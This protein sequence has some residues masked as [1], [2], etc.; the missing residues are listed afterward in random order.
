[1]KAA[2]IP[3]LLG[4]ALLG[5][6]GGAATVL[7]LAPRPPATRTVALAPDTAVAPPARDLGARLAELAAENRDLRER[8]AALELRPAVVP[9][10]PIEAFVP[11]ET[12]TAFEAEVRAALARRDVLPEAAPELKERVADV[13]IDLRRQEAQEKVRRY[14]EARAARLDQ[15]LEKLA[16]WLELNAHQA[17]EM[18]AVLER[19][20]TREDEV[21]RLWEEGVEDEVL[22]ERKRAD[23]ELFWAEAAEVLT[24][25]QLATFREGIGADGKD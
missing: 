21:R 8:V 13:L 9:R 25:D 24:P 18:R 23:G 17:T 2:A 19:Q 20:Y 3:A 7:V 4:A 12:F 10:A 1:M 15:D 5:G 16:G 14:Q 11:L 22:G 6:A